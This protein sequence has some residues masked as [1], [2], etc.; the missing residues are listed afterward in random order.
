[1]H[2]EKNYWWDAHSSLALYLKREVSYWVQSVV[3]DMKGK[4][5]L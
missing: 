5:W 2:M 4:G 3:A 1:M